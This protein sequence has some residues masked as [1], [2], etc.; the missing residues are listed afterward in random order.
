MQ[1]VAVCQVFNTCLKYLFFCI[2]FEQLFENENFPVVTKQLASLW[3][4]F[5]LWCPS[6]VVLKYCLLFYLEQATLIFVFHAPYYLNAVKLLKQLGKYQF[7]SSM[8]L[9]HIKCAHN[10]IRKT[11]SIHIFKADI[12]NC[13]LPKLKDDFIGNFGEDCS[14]VDSTHFYYL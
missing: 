6:S 14:S 7:M 9:L 4:H 1:S 3:T 8:S 13:K 2:Y 10:L 12:C 11:W 5:N